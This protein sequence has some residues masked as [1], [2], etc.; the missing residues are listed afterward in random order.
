M[1]RHLIDALKFLLQAFSQFKGIGLIAQPLEFLG[2]DGIGLRTVKQPLQGGLGFI[3]A[4]FK[5][6]A[7]ASL[8]DQ[9]HRGE[10][11]ILQD[12]QFV[13]IKLVHGSLSWRGVIAQI[14]KD[15]AHMGPIFLFDMG[16][17]ILFVG[18]TA[19]ELDFVLITE[20][21]EVIVDKF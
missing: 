9:L 16:V 12:S 21:L 17:V 5:L 14:A 11:Q 2:L 6:R 15:F 19:G 7:D 1:V 10:K 18:T 8:F 4:A 20:G 3:I 13:L